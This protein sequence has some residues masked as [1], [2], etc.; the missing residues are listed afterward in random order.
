MRKVL[1]GI[2]LEHKKN[3]MD[4]ATEYLPT[5]NEVRISMSQHIGASC[6]PLVAVGDTVKIGQKIGDTDAFVSA[7]VHSSV[8]GKV[9]SIERIM[10]IQ[11]TYD[12]MVTIRTDGKHERW[13][14]LEPPTV[15]TREEFVAAVRESGIVGLGGAAFPASVKYSP[16]NLAE[17]NTLIINGAECEPYITSDY[18][19]MI[20][21]A[22]DVVKG[23]EIVMKHLEMERAYIGIESN[24]P[25]AISLL[26]ELTKD[27]PIDV[28]RLRSLYPKGAERVL[29]YEISGKALPAG[30]LPADV[31]VLVSNVTSIAAVAHYFTTGNPL[32]RKR[33]T[34][35]GDAVADP[36]NIMAPIGTKI[37]EIVAFC[38]G[39]KAQPSKL[40]MGGPMMGRSIYD[41]G[42]PIIKNN[43]AILALSE[44]EV[45]KIGHE[46]QCI[47]CGRCVDNCPIELMPTTIMRAYER[48]D[49]EDLKALNV[50]VCM[51]C[52]CCAYV[53]PARKPLSLLNRMAKAFLAESERKAA[54]A[55][56]AAEERGD[57]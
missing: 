47:N 19:T 39:Y 16:K 1:R 11:G 26:E 55:A 49:A 56:K 32:T 30:K 36:K 6:E 44:K 38:G 9:T 29:I 13:E 20:E 25:K 5:P 40:L 54:E 15:N 57:E 17:V 24:K 41:D 35:D 10:S 48:G 18:R 31:G 27:K 14:G 34:V 50:G 45:S 21:Q 33:I 23:T 3:T 7:P 2:K 42:K 46:T 22:D 51:E 43:N 52:G 8:S 53:C 4:C 37:Y 28:V 12:P